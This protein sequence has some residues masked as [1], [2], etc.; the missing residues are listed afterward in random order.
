MMWYI[1]MCALREFMSQRELL[2]RSLRKS[3]ASEAAGEKIRGV[4][5]PMPISISKCS[6]EF[7]RHR[8]FKYAWFCSRMLGLCT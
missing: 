2:M 4:W 6:K 8:F 5:K 3:A 1:D 7:A